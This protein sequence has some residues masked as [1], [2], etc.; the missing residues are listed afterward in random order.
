M[1]IV[2]QT[3]SDVRFAHPLTR[4]FLFAVGFGLFLGALVKVVLQKRCLFPMLIDCNRNTRENY[5]SDNENNTIHAYS[6]WMNV[7]FSRK[8]NHV[9]L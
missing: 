9:L 4:A 8:E 5:Q 6:L 1:E 2:V 7:A 3:G